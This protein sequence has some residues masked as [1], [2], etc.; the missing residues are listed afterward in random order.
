[1]GAGQVFKKLLCPNRIAYANYDI[2]EANSHEHIRA[3]LK[4]Q[5]AN[6][7]QLNSNSKQKVCINNILF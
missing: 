1:M 7:W 2:V 6:R 4:G 3:Q 5:K